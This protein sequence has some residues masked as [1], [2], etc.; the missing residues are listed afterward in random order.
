M[1][2]SHRGVQGIGLWTVDCGINASQHTSGW[3]GTGWGQASKARIA[4]RGPSRR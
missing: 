4:P 2:V 3:T 1:P